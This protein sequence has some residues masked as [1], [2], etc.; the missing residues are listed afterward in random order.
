L[1]KR[2]FGSSLFVVCAALALGAACSG[3]D[4]PGTAPRGGGGSGGNGH[5][6]ASA[7]SGGT[8]QGG[9]NTTG[10]ADLL[11]SFV[12]APGGDTRTLTFP[13]GLFLKFQFPASA[14]GTRV[15]LR[16]VDDATL[17][18]DG[19]FPHLIEM[20]P[21]G[22]QFNPPV[23][24]T[25]DWTKETPVLRTFADAA[26]AAQPEVLGISSNL[27]AFELAHFSYIAVDGISYNCPFPGTDVFGISTLCKATQHEQWIYCDNVSRCTSVRV[28]CCNDI[29]GNPNFNCTELLDYTAESPIT[30][31]P[32]AP[33]P[34][35][36]PR[37]SGTPDAPDPIGPP[38][39]A[40]QADSGQGAGG[41]GGSG[42]GGSGG[43]G[44]TGGP[45]A[46]GAGGQ[47]GSNGCPQLGTYSIAASGSCGDLDT[48]APRQRL[49]G[50]DPCS[51][52]WE[53]DNQSTNFGVT[54]GN[55][56][57][58]TGG[59]TTGLTIKLGSADYTCTATVANGGTEVTLACVTATGPAQ[60]CTVTATRTG[61]L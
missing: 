59:P 33:P 5:S 6:D 8:A 45:G 20:L 29:V 49:D 12:I 43:S 27:A 53:T 54:S 19:K 11:G 50:R 37:D 24:V 38:D 60:S 46:G 13:D 14:A 55:L 58:D 23:L 57:Y 22:I 7:G 16:I 17:G 15:T 39:A 31:P 25:P 26:G 61:P 47:G 44:G 3:D 34:P 36:P 56:P 18:L 10:D 48:N 41:A 32:C 2:G 51:R 28:H 30:Y 42:Q 4:A 35:P 52:Y 40:G 1:K 9:Q 21:H